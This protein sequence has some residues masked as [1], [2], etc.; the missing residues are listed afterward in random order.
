MLGL[1]LEGGGAKGAYHIG[2][3]KAFREVG[4]EFN[5]ITGTSVGALNGGLIIQGDFEAAWN[6]WYNVTPQ[7]IM[8]LDDDI[9]VMLS[10]RKLDHTNVMVLIEEIRRTIKNSGIDT[11][12][13]YNMI[14]QVMREDIIRKSPMDFGFVTYSI[15]DRKLLELFKED[16][17][18]GKLA[19]YLMA[20]SYL[21]VFKERLLDGKLFLDGAFYNNLPVNML[22]RKG[23]EEIYAVRLYQAGRIKKIDPGETTIHYIVPERELGGIL[24]FNRESSRHNL[25][26]GYLDTLRKLKNYKG[27]RFYLTDFPEESESLQMMLQWPEEAQKEVCRILGLKPSKALNR[28]FIEE[29]VPDLMKLAGLDDFNG[30]QDLLLRIMEAT[31]E[32]CEVDYLKVYTFDEWQRAVT[33]CPE[34]EQKNEAGKMASLLKKS[35]ILFRPGREKKKEALL[36]LFMENRDWFTRTSLV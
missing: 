18:E 13:L 12:P 29:A 2:A 6:L 36:R 3:W 34:H 17:P 11:S 23:Y 24:D 25:Q 10:D 27:Q 21:P 19:D 22:L 4:M 15:T 9:Y 33:A 30:Y 14:Q 5:G 26:L 7:Q 1:T 32:T 31:A 28:L 35:E 16:I 20:S 8:T